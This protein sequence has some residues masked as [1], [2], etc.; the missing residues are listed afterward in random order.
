MKVSGSLPRLDNSVF[1]FS[2][3]VKSPSSGFEFTI[4]ESGIY[5]VKN[6]ITFSGNEGYVFDQSGH[7]CGGYQSGVPFDISVHYSRDFTGFSYYF[8]NTLIANNMSGMS[9]TSSAA[10]VPCQVEFDK[11]GDSS[12]FVIATGSSNAS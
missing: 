8:N 11:H 5:P 12:L 6:I 3:N 9:G 1:D 2:I 7:L 10:G 4:Q